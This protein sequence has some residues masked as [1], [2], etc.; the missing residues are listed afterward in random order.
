MNR[1]HATA[2][3]I[4]TAMAYKR[5][6]F[7]NRVGENVGG[8][9]FEYYK[10][11]LASASGHTRWVQHW[12]SE[13][14]RLIETELVIVLLHPIRGFKDRKKTAQEMIEEI[15]AIDSQ[16]RR[17]AEQTIR[18]DYGLKKL[19]GRISDEDTDNFHQTVQRIID[20]HA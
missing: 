17:A 7:K 8:A 16:Y 20:T 9:L 12:R 4:L 19:R 11:Q 5:E 1:A 18:H 13:V 14:Q 3:D 10:A 2:E 6:D 15:R